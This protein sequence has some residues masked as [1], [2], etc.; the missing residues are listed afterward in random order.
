[1]RRLLRFLFMLI[2]VSSI[3]GGIGYL[4]TTDNTRKQAV[5]YYDRVTLAVETAIA[6]T[7]FELTRTA[8]ANLPHYRYM[9]IENGRPLIEI[10]EQFNTTIDAIR[11]ANGLLPTVDVGD[12][13]LVVVPEGV[14]EL[15]P[16]RRLRAVEAA[17]G[18]TL[19]TLAV[20]YNADVDLVLIDNPVL[21][22][23]Q[24]LPGDLVFIPETLN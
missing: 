15:L 13:S 21:A 22:D 4:I 2:L 19:E 17:A 16:P 14:Q 18:D 12:G 10:A 24:L 9:T 20:R 11:M 5:I 3:V 8:E 23:R 7:L 1:M 6:R